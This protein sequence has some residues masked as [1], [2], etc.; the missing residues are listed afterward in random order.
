[1]TSPLMT[2]L[3]AVY[4][5]NLC[6]KT[7]WRLIYDW[8]AGEQ[9]GAFRLMNYGYLEDE[10]TTEGLPGEELCLR[11]YR[12][13]AGATDLSGKI[14]LEVGAGRGGGLAHLK[15]ALAPRAAIGLDLSPRA[16]ALARRLAT[17]VPGVSFVQGDAE[18]LPFGD[19]FFDAVLNVESSHCYP[20]RERFFREVQRVLVPGGHFLYADFF[21]VEAIEPVR[22]ALQAAP[23]RIVSERDITAQVLAALRRDEGRR[24]L[25]IAR[26]APWQQHALRN[27][28]ATTDSETYSLLAR[29]ARRY[30]AF[31]LLAA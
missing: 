4:N 10:Q 14:L 29:G 18:Q 13:V 22:H 27:F 28:A 24:L 1:M 31:D 16:V 20:S 8:M 17:G 30:L 3:D 15:E 7:L 26:V 25:L 9:P 12:Q 6:R 21:A 5:T 2:A 23:L 11:L 19:A